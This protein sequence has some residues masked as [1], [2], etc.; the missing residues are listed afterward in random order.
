MHDAQRTMDDDNPPERIMSTLNLAL[1]CVGLMRTATTDE[2]EK[3]KSA[4]RI[5]KLW[6][7]AEDPDIKREMIDS[8]EPV[9]VW[10]HSYSKL[11]HLRCKGKQCRPRSN[12]S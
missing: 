3:L 2:C 5:T 10:Y 7:L 11:G 8:T 9:K 12:C 6:E 1:Q 4:S